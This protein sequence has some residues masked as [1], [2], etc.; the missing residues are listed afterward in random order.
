VIQQAT[1]K[2]S[3]GSKITDDRRKAVQDLYLPHAR[4]V[5]API[6]FAIAIVLVVVGW[7]LNLDDYITAESGLGYGLGLSGGI[8]LLLV[9]LYPIRKRVRWMRNW[10][11]T[12][13]WFSTH[14][15]MG[16]L[17]P[18]LILYH[19]NFQLGA[20]NSNITLASMLLVVVSGLVGRYIYGKIHYG[21]YGRHA[22]L[23][24]LQNDSVVSLSSLDQT[25]K[26]APLVKKRI[27]SF[28]TFALQSSSNIFQ[29]TY[30]HLSLSFRLW[31]EYCLASIQLQQIFNTSAR[32]NPSEVDNP[33]H[34]LRLKAARRYLLSHL[35]CMRKVAEFRYY[36]RL[37]GLWH[38]VHVPFIYILVFT[39][40][41]HVYAVHKY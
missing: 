36:E 28:Q 11:Q 8:I 3:D 18:L 22:T 13:N 31:W 9:L 41:Y 19:C 26:F 5:L 1:N 32:A 21:L 33:A 6:F 29:G 4:N 10:G 24:E 25:F 17:G 12:R 16:I 27:Y 15:V 23:Q 34:R 7:R 14:M 39:A 20:T 30:K 2:K 38:A 40:I 35:L 37:F